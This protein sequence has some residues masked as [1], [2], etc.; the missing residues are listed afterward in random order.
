MAYADGR[1]QIVFNGEIYNF[2]D[3]RRQLERAGFSFMTRSDTEV[4]MAAYLHWGLDFVKQLNGMFG[5]ALWDQAKKRLVLARDRVGK[6]PLYYRMEG[7]AIAFASELK[8]LVA[9]GATTG[10]VDSVALDCYF[11]LGY[12]PA[13]K[14]IY[15]DVRKLEPGSVLVLSEG[16]LSQHRYWTLEFEEPIDCSLNEAVEAFEPV[17]RDAVSRRL[18]SE[19]PL[20][21]FL[22]GG[23][24]SSLIVAEMADQL[25]APV[26]THTIGF[27]ESEFSE[28]R[29][30]GLIAE[31]L[32][33][34][35][36]AYTVHPNAADVLPAIANHF[37]EP[38]ADSSALPTW[39]VCE[40]TK[41][42]VTVALSGDGGDE[43]F[44]GYTFRYFPHQ[45][46]ARLRARLPLWIRYLLF[47]PMGRI[48]P[49][50]PKL[51]GWLRFKTI[52]ENLARGDAEAFYHDLAV[53]RADARKAMYRPEFNKSL[54]G[55]TAMEFVADK[56][57]DSS[58]RTPLSRA[59]FADVNCYMTDDVLV[60]V[61]RMS[62]AH[63]LEVRAPLLDV[64]VLEFAARLP[65]AV[66]MQGQSGKLVLR[67]LVKRRL[68]PEIYNLPKKGFSIPAAAWL[69]TD[70]RKTTED[71]LF[72]NDSIIAEYLEPTA[73]RAQ[74]QEHLT[75]RRDHSQFLWGLMMFGLWDQECR[76]AVRA[77]NAGGLFPA[78][79]N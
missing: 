28:L 58:A 20:G 66:K 57:M 46:E 1:I 25:D 50:S 23:I 72:G 15:K 12:I 10:A 65:D 63:S 64:N 7:T 62:M 68:P 39:Y 29:E 21:A 18:M 78:R 69:R 60:K 41:R 22:S 77:G 3:I 37:D 42:S 14:C 74:W 24:D 40:M 67:E 71:L 34:D 44:G 56:Y 59:Q 52:F 2:L 11:T 55:A 6:K 19:V 48:W 73:V 70:L 76:T 30:A 27:D 4:I 49:A 8:S 16:R 35:H 75:G 53:S 33:A 32:G 79:G 17:L 61:D 13:P 31:H 43:A 47:A 26:K 51:P 54:K 38:F 5:L 9:G 45:V 36:Q